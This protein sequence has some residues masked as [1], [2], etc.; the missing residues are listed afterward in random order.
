MKSLSVYWDLVAAW[1]FALDY[2]LLLCTLRLAGRAVRRR[3]VA[4]AAALGA[5]YSVAALA[6]PQLIWMLLPVAFA[7]CRVAFGRAP[8]LIKLSLLYLLLSC[9]LGG[10]VLLLGSLGG[11]LARLTRGMVL[12]ELPWGVF[13]AA[14][15][16]S[17]LLLSLIFRGGAKHDG[18]D[19]VTARIERGG[20]AAEV[21]LLRDTGNALT[22]PLTGEGVPVIEET[23]LLPL[24]EP[25]MFASAAHEGITPLRADTVGGALTLRAFRCDALYVG[26]QNLGARLV[27]LTPENFGGGY[28]GIWFAEE[29]EEKRHDLETMVG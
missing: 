19:F 16:A 4:A 2:I 15:G 7:M 3:R 20:A 9:G 13:C 23:A 29:T 10:L 26:G 22:D 5:A 28:Q 17:Y 1:N 11:S 8:R 12:A 21:R 25:K 27:A 18:A 14:L 6:L 24:L